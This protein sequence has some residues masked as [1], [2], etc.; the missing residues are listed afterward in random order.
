MYVCMYV[1][2][3]VVHLQRKHCKTVINVPALKAHG[4]MAWSPCF[5]LVDTL[6]QS[7]EKKVWSI[8]VISKFSWI[9]NFGEFQLLV[10]SNL[11]SVLD[12]LA[13]WPSH[14]DFKFWVKSSFGWISNFGEVQLSENSNFLS[15]KKAW[16]ISVVPNSTIS[17]RVFPSG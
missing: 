1:C 4:Y 15:Q 9:P 14:S 11:E 13:H 17:C 5:G 12:S 8:L 16:Y 6:T 2:M 3:Y 10:N 7:L